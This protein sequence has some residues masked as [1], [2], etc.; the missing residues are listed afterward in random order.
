MVLGY[1]VTQ[2]ELADNLYEVV[3]K[4]RACFAMLSLFASNQRE[5]GLLLQQRF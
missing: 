2:R 1:I 3:S 5:L 4:R